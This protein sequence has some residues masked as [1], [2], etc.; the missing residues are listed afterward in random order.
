L[1]IETDQYLKHKCQRV[2]KRFLT[3]KLLAAVVKI[4]QVDKSL[5]FTDSIS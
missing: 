2:L 5:K 1:Y 3:R 4:R